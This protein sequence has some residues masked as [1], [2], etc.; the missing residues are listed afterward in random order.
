MRAMRLPTF[1]ADEVAA[2]WP[3]I[4]PLIL[5]GLARYFNEHR[6]VGGFLTACLHND[7]SEA[8]AR[9]DYASFIALREIMAALSDEPPSIAWGSRDKVAAWLAKETA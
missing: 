8:V 9:S 5:E 2:K 3:G 7:L 4:P 1:D 6:P